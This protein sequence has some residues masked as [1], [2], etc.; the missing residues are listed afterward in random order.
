MRLMSISCSTLIGR[1]FWSFWVQGDVVCFHIV[2]VLAWDCTLWLNIYR[3][4]WRIDVYGESHVSLR[5]NT[6]I[7]R[8]MY[9]LVIAAE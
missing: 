1:K 5:M 9:I 4:V 3:I 8:I 7:L 6:Y 2:L